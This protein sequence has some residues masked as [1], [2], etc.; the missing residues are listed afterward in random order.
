M[1]TAPGTLLRV[2]GLQSA[3]EYNGLRHSRHAV[4]TVVPQHCDAYDQNDMYSEM[5]VHASRNR[6]SCCSGGACA[7]PIPSAAHL[8]WQEDPLAPRQPGAGRPSRRVQQGACGTAGKSPMHFNRHRTDLKPEWGALSPQHDPH[9]V[10]REHC[11]VSGVGAGEQ[12]AR[13]RHHATQWCRDCI[14]PSGAPIPSELS[15]TAVTGDETGDETSWLGQGSEP[16]ESRGL[17]KQD[18]ADLAR[19]NIS[20]NEKVRAPPQSR[21]RVASAGPELGSS[22]QGL[23]CPGDS[24]GHYK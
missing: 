11:T 17:T 15:C 16:G 7:R 20:I 21:R 3:D 6:L 10:V 12:A 5:T 13:Q 19:L 22:R 1:D 18:L 23:L 9:R 2:R 4:K 8:E 14:A 24:P